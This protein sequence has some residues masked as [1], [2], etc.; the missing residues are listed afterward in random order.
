MHDSIDFRCCVVVRQTDAEHS[1][2][3]VQ[4][5]VSGEFIRVVVAGP[6]VDPLCGERLSKR[7]GSMTRVGDGYGGNS[8]LQPVRLSNTLDLNAPYALQLMYELLSQGPLIVRGCLIGA[9]DLFAAF[10]RTPGLLAQP[11]EVVRCGGQA[12]EQFGLRCAE[13]MPSR[14]LLRPTAHRIGI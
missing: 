13:F 9:L 11:D 3:F 1:L 5:Q 10:S 6:N 4:A 14:L 8:I 7:R 12:G 2:S